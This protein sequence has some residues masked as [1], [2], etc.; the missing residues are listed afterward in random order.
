MWG[1]ARTGKTF[2]TKIYWK[3]SFLN[4]SDNSKEEV[5]KSIE[6]L[7]KE[8][9]NIDNDK[10]EKEAKNIFLLLTYGAIYGVLRKVSMAI[11]SKEAEQIYKNIEDKIPTPDIKLINQAIYL[12]FNKNMDAKSLRTL[13]E[14]FNKNPSLN[15]NITL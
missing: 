7:L 14:E 13:S 1:H 9:P 3:L 15:K 4:I 10:L 2:C 8:N 5:V 12:Q 11:G 6:H